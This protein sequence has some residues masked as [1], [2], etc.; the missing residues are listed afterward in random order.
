VVH[1]LAV[2]RSFLPVVPAEL[3]V[4]D[5]E[6]PCSYLP[7][8][9]ARRPLR[10]PVRRLTGEEFDRR[11]DAGDRRT[12]TFLY[13]QACPT[14]RACEPIRV[15]V[16]AFAPS[17]TQRRVRAKGDARVEVRVGPIEVDGQRVALYDRHLS[18]RELDSG[19]PPIDDVG[20]EAFLASS[21]VDGF[22]IRYVVD[23]ELA[24]VAITDRGGRSL[25]AVY[26]YWDPRHAQLSLGT[27]SILTQIEL[28]R[29]AGLDWVYLGLAIAANHSMAYKLRFLPHERRI[30]GVWRRFARS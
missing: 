6:E 4:Y 20:Y 2:A 19:H 13:T 22:E 21:C 12:G 23:G 1:S 17:R 26:T 16:R 14:C 8:Q 27:Y 3:I 29:R 15:D 25:S 9:T 10:Q 18:E 5:R 30:D 7:G 11:L 24:A 28:A